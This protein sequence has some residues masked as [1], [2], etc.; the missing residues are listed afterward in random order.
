MSDTT[1][2]YPTRLLPDGRLLAVYPLTFGR[3]RL[4]VGPAGES[5]FTDEW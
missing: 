2:D 4:G 5:H 1:P 3:G